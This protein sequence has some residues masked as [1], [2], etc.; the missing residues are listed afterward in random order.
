L[1]C[2]SSHT[3]SSYPTSLND[4]LPISGQSGKSPPP[5]HIRLS[6]EMPCCRQVRLLRL[7]GRFRLLSMQSGIYAFT[8]AP[9]HLSL[10]TAI[11]KNLSTCSV[12][13]INLFL[14]A[15]IS[16]CS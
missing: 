14:I 16:E 13:S 8:P 12:L 4:D 6:S 10:V 1:P 9:V 2:H 5:F 15:A 11:L 7:W 3:S